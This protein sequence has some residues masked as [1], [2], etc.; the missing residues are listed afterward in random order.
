MKPLAFCTKYPRV[1]LLVG[2][3]AVFAV[4]CAEGLVATVRPI[5]A[6]K[7]NDS[8]PASGLAFNAEAYVA[9]IWS[10]RVLPAARD[11]S[12]SLPELLTAIAKNKTAALRKFGHKVGGAY[13]MLVRFSGKVSQ[14]NTASP[15]GSITVDVAKGSGMVP[16]KV[17]VGPVILGTTLRDALKFISFG[18]FLN[19]IQ[20]GDV[21]DELNSEVSKQVVKPLHLARLKGRGVKVLGAYTYNVGNPR[22]ITVTPV[23]LDVEHGKP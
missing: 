10:K 21:A 20:Y 18:E 9:Q 11:D 19:Q 16:V 7:V 22:D 13:N 6:T 2:V 23:I 3:C 17:A 4:L 1:A 5:G 15:I 12:T 14:I 8:S